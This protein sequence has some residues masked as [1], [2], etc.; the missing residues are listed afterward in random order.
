VLLRDWS[1]ARADFEDWARPPYDLVWFGHL[2][3]YLG[4]GDLID[5]PAIVDLDN[6]WDRW[7][8]YR[9]TAVRA[10]G[11]RPGAPSALRSRVAQLADMVDERKYARVHER[12]AD[13]V[14]AVL[15]CSELDRERLARDNVVVIP[16]AYPAPKPPAELHTVQPGGPTFVMTGSS[17]YLPNE[18]AVRWFATSILPT[19]RGALPQANLRVVGERA[20]SSADLA[21]E[22]GIELV[23]PVDDIRRELDAADVVVAPLRYGGGTR[24]KLLEAF[25]HRLPAVATTVGCEGLDVVNGTQL[26]IADDEAAFAAACVRAATD[27]P[28][29]A[30]LTGAA[31]DLYRARYSTDVV[32]RL[33]VDVVQH[34]LATSS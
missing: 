12:I 4:V 22:A 33:V 2:D 23:G 9:R 11:K 17:K 19:I 25:A 16:N 30:A 14:G 7:L 24:V 26:L 1:R 32:Q 13:R 21:A 18:D 8:Q 6:L 10:G 34:V 29:R 20:D 5:A 15:V 27:E 28:L 31:W 3:T